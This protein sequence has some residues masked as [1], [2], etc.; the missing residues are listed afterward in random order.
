MKLACSSDLRKNN[1]TV[2]G[3]G[4]EKNIPNLKVFILTILQNTAMP[5]TGCCILQVLFILIGC[6]VTGIITG[7]WFLF[8]L[9]PVVGYGFAW[10]GHFFIEKNKPATFT[11]PFYSLASDF[12][13]FW[14]M[15]TGQIEARMENAKR[16]IN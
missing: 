9:I 6:L 5:Q 11:Y 4:K 10:V 8:V 16:T 7:K 3:W 14:H 12:V 13:M 15:L 2:P 1:N